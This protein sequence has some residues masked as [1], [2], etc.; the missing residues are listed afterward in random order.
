MSIPNFVT[1]FIQA[2]AENGVSDL[3]FEKV[4]E[5]YVFTHPVTQAMWHGYQIGHRKA[6]RFRPGWNF[7][8]GLTSEGLQISENPR[9][10]RSHSAA[11]K[12]AINHRARYGMP[13]V[14]LSMPDASY[15]YMKKFYSG[16]NVVTRQE[17]EIQTVP[18]IIRPNT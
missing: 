12:I 9:G 8:A 17:D 5:E 11:T 13:F 14:V 18:F 2:A 3:H 16:S 15:E 6:L 4:D 7:L 1:H 10:H